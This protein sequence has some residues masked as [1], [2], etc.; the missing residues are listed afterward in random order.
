MFAID[1]I[2]KLEKEIQSS[3]KL[4]PSVERWLD[5][6]KELELEL[7]NK[8]VFLSKYIDQ[9]PSQILPSYSTMIVNILNDD[10]IK[11]S[12]DMPKALADNILDLAKALEKAGE[13]TKASD[14]RTALKQFKK[15]KDEV[16]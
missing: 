5:G 2:R 7:S 13:R 4:S 9:I 1:S 12:L 10:E 6:T 15:F 14:V 3:P 11:D 16:I 8:V